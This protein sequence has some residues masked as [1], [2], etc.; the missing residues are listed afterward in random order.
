MHLIA[1]K[2]ELLAA[3]ETAEKAT[4]KT[5]I[6][7][8]LLQVLL[9]ADAEGLTVTGTDN[10][11]LICETA[12]VEVKEPGAIAING[13]LLLEVLQAALTSGAESV[14]LKTG[15]GNRLHVTSG[16]AAYNL[17][18]FSA[19]N[20]PAIPAVNVSPFLK[21]SGDLFKDVTKKVL[22]VL[23]SASA[24]MA[25]Y[26]EVYV[27]GTVG[28]NLTL[29]STDSVRLSM[30]ELLKGTTD[31]EV[32]GKFA[33]LVPSKILK[34]VAGLARFDDKIAISFSDEQAVFAFGTTELRGRLSDKTFPNFR[35][36][37]PKSQ[38]RMVKVDSDALLHSLRGVMPLAKDSKNKILV[39][40]TDDRV[41]IT[42]T[43]PEF[44]EARREVEAEITEG[45]ALRLAFNGKYLL[46]FLGVAE[47]GQVNW[48][49]TKDSFPATL[50][51]ASTEVGFNYVVMPITMSF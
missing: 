28:G 44:G 20:Y 41:I 8:A 34:L 42:S 32:L 4:A 50:Q 13:E 30:V 27:E 5:A 40:F 35:S 2:T 12:T 39:E 19:E 15:E 17:A 49:V 36:I 14:E 37:L 6:E 45:K 1:N 7:P 9:A 11:V 38:G 26:D 10:H 43:S 31:L 25:T 33:V 23:G 21:M 3:V 46:D 51:P 16:K 24:G 48:G 29:C 47:R 18:A 22:A